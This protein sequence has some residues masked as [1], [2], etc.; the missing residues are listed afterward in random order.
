[1]DCP[2]CTHTIEDPGAHE[3]PSCHS[4]LTPYFHLNTLN[5]QRKALRNWRAALVAIVLGGLMILLSVTI[6]HSN[7]VKE[8]SALENQFA[9]HKEASQANLEELKALL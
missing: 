9:S 2:V 6:M 1:M 4:D 5:R 8:G 7:E 3:C